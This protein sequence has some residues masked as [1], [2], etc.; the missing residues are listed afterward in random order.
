MFIFTVNSSL[1]GTKQ[2]LADGQQMPMDCRAIARNEL[3]DGLVQCR[4]CQTLLA[5]TLINAYVP[6][7]TLVQIEVAR[8]AKSRIPV[9]LII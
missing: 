7:C 5:R 2:S 4:S 8:E 1:R 3:N 6:T 9:V